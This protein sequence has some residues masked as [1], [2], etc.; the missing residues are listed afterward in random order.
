[1]ATASSPEV[2]ERRKVRTSRSRSGGQVREP[3]EGGMRT[4]S[5]LRV[6][7]FPDVPLETQV[8]VSASP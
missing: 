8:L 6:S 2:G 1:M 7:A 3:L 4:A 5:R